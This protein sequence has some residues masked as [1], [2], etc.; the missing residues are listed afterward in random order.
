MLITMSASVMH[1]VW[2]A[3][4]VVLPTFFWFWF[5]WRRDPK[6]EPVRLLIRTF[7]YGAF[8][9]LPAALFEL[10]FQTALKGIAL[11]V[12]IAVLEELLKFFATRTVVKEKDFDEFIDGLIY[13]MTAALGFALM[14]NIFYGASFGLEVLLVRGLITMSSH[15]LFTAPWGFA[16]GYQRMNNRN[17]YAV[18]LGLGIGIVLHSIFNGIQIQSHPTWGVIALVVGLVTVMFLAADRLYT[19]ASQEP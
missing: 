6:P 13:S 17:K 11:Y 12:V 1:I 18:P 9:Y 7:L 5:F 19:T 14:E 4:G 10:S 16:L 2:F 3:L 8:A 15:V